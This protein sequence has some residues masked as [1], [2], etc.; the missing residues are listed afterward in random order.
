[1]VPILFAALL[2]VGC[3]GGGSGGESGYTVSFYS[4]D[5]KLL[6]TERGRVDLGIKAYE[7][8]VTSWYK[9][10]ETNATF[11]Y[12]TPTADTK[13][14]AVADV[15]EVTDATQL[16]DIRSA[17]SSDKFILGG[18]ISVDVG[19]LNPR[20]W[21]PIPL[22]TGTFE[23]DG[24]TIRGVW[25]N[26][27]TG[28]RTGLFSSV[29][30]GTI[31][32]LNVEIDSRGIKGDGLVGTIAGYAKNSTI[33]NVTVT[34]DVIGGAYVG[35][36]VG[37]ANNVTIA[38]SYYDGSVNGN[39]IVG[40]IAGIAYYGSITDSH[41]KGYVNG[42]NNI[43]GIVG[44]L[45][46]GATI[47]DSYSEGSIDGS[48]SVGGIAGHVY[49][50]TIANSHS[51]GNISGNI[52]VGGIAGY[53][54]I[55]A[56]I[57][58][59]HSIGNINGG[60]EI[61]GIIGTAYNSLITRS[62]SKGNVSGT[63]DFVGGIAGSVYGGTNINNTYSHGDVTSTLSSVGGIA[64]GVDGSKI[65]SSYS[66][67]NISG[68]D[69]VGGIVG[70]ADS[71]SEIKRNAAINPSVYATNV[72][73]NRVIGDFYS[74]AVRENNFALNAT[75][76]NGNPVDDDEHD[77]VNGAKKVADDFKLKATYENATNNGG[78]GWDFTDIWDINDGNGYPYLR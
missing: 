2:F 56:I 12:F 8:R 48:S 37:Y 68:H 5:L 41:S 16:Y 66:T 31:R 63:E 51:V 64:G 9:S 29:E 38:N 75:L 30:N 14:F 65:T 77:G 52:S 40:G 76:I 20:G 49:N 72:G 18:D 32:N 44:Y 55:S 74:S 53:V 13:F 59:S 47:T 34:G 35:A 70:A 42:T 36:I 15:E 1:L 27:N 25:I 60:R 6:S 57:T 78:L 62:Y 54:D 33:D 22:F 73:V 19:P 26:D 24:H 69:N 58:D 46:Y 23:G 43:G 45:T 71:T 3:G 50:G 10:G 7:H 11:G 4:A 39:D 67:G 21:T 28:G 17:T 61:G